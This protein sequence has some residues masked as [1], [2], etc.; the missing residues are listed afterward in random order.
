MRKGTNVH[1]LWEKILVLALKNLNQ[2]LYFL[3]LRLIYNLKQS[4]QKLNQF[5][6]QNQIY[7]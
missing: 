3:C 1:S 6:D 7:T 2:F 4:I 5:E